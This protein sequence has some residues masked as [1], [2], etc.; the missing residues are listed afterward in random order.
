MCGGGG[1]SHEGDSYDGDPT[2]PRG[3]SEGDLLNIP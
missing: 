3:G 2:E 1:S